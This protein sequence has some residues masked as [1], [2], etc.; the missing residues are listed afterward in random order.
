MARH[1]AVLRAVSSKLNLGVLCAALGGAAL[2]ESTLVLA[3]GVALFFGLVTREVH[4]GGRRLH[5]Y[6]PR[7]PDGATFENMAIR[8]AV[9]GIHAA[10]KERLEAVRA[11]S[12][13][14]L[15]LLDDVLR[16]SV[17]LET[18]ALHLAR[19][20][21]RLHS[22]LTRKDLGCVRDTLYS[23][24]QSA[25]LARSPAEREIYDAAAQSY[26]IKVE[27]LTAIDMGIRVSIARLEHIRATLSVV[28]PRIVKLCAS[29]A[30]LADTSH[31]RLSDE[32]RAASVELQEAEDRFHQLA[33]GVPDEPF[34]SPDS[35]ARR[36]GG[37][38][39]APPPDPAEEELAAADEP[40]RGRRS[41]AHVAL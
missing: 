34:S 20:T 6:S 32:L 1:Q 2:L 23:I 40:A 29:S 9:D 14:V 13:D 36:S 15:R 26:A 5:H 30:D 18:A 24:Q 19:R 28:P 16:S 11:C 39:V 41:S 8:L 25:Q 10:Q 37:I 17:A 4:T 7:I 33:Q 31:V 12:D 3:L 22:Y 35:R 21:D 38:R 27:T